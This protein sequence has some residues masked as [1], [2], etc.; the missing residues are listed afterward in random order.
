M[1]QQHVPIKRIQFL[2]RNIKKS[3][4]LPKSIEYIMSYMCIICVKVCAIQ[5]KRKKFPTIKVSPTKKAHPNK[6]TPI[7]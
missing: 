4:I 3:A 6:Y 1:F 7:R 2:E 5:K